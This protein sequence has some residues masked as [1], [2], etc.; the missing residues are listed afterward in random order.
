MPDARCGSAALKSVEATL[1]K[2]RLG[3]VSL[4]RISTDFH[5]IEVRL[6]HLNFE[7]VELRFRDTTWQFLQ[8]L[9]F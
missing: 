2:D 6:S 4:A 8:F 7:G 1:S 5:V 3:R 9:Q